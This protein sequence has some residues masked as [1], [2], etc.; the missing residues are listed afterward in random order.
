MVLRPASAAD[1]YSISV[2]PSLYAGDAGWQSSITYANS[3]G[4]VSGAGGGGS[5]PTAAAPLFGAD[6]DVVTL[7][8]PRGDIVGY[9]LTGPTVAAV[10]VGHRVIRTISSPALPAGDR[11]AVF[12]IPSGA[13]VTTISGPGLL[14]AVV[15]LPAAFSGR[16]LRVATLAVVP[17]DRAGRAIRIRPSEP[18]ESWT[19]L[20]FWQARSA[21]TP[22]ITEPPYHGPTRPGDGVCLFGQHGLPGL[23]PEWGHTV[24]RLSPVTGAEGELFLSCVNTE[25]YL[26]GWP[27]DAAILL[28]ARHPGVAPGGIP[29]ALPVPFFPR[30]VDLEAAGLTARRIGP[31]WIAVQGGSG[32]PQRLRVLAALRI[33]RLDLAAIRR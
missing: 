16:R 12:F 18:A 17:L 8:Q 20:H 30:T 22:N 24:A 32:L 28:D 31:A 5:Y 27:I 14:P 10:R 1:R 11:A 4:A 29:G 7:P 15:A 25:Y 26:H 13:M 23:T 6:L 3:R 33:A 19:A 21:V 2:Y 9:V